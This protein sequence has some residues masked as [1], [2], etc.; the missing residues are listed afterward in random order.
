VAGS[1]FHQCRTPHAAIQTIG[2]QLAPGAGKK[3]NTDRRHE[4]DVSLSLVLMMLVLRFESARKRDPYP[5][6]KLPVGPIFMA[7]APQ[8]FRFI[9]L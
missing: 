1:K 7:T 2:S 3:A 4:P 9:R 6:R 5:G 8:A